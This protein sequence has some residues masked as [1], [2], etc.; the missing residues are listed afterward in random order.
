MSI[1][2]AEFLIKIVIISRYFQDIGDICDSG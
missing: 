1:G 2:E